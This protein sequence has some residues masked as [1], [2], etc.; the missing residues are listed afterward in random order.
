MDPCPTTKI[1]DMR[2]SDLFYLFGCVTD[3]NI[4]KPDKDQNHNNLK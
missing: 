2:Y 4:K 3:A 1:S